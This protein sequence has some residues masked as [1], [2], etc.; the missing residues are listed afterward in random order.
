[1]RFPRTSHEQVSW[2][3]CEQNCRKE[4]IVTDKET[5]KQ[6][7]ID[8]N[9]VMSPN[10]L[11]T[12]DFLDELIGS[13]VSVLKIEGSDM[14]LGIQDLLAHPTHPVSRLCFARCRLDAGVL[15]D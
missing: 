8:N 3:F 11:S 15:D 13:G 5:G 2:Q 6:L 14:T 12:I 4:Y 1:M 7:E 10:D 9:F